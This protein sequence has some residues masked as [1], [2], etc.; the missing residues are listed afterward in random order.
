MQTSYSQNT[1]YYCAAVGCF[2]DTKKVGKYGYM[3][4]VTFFAFPTEKKDPKARRTW[5]NLLRR[6][7][8]ND[9]PRNHRLCSRH[10]VD[11]KPTVTHPYPT[12][13]GY[14]NYK[15][16]KDPRQTTSIA[17]RVYPVDSCTQVSETGDGGSQDRHGSFISQTVK[18]DR[19]DGF[20]LPVV[21]EEIIEFSDEVY[22][23][24]TRPSVPD[25]EYSLQKTDKTEYSQQD[26]STQ[27]DISMEDIS[28]L[29]L[30]EK[31]CEDPNT[32]LKESFI[33]KVTETDA[34]VM[35]YT[36]VQTKSMLMGMF[37]NYHE[38]WI[39][40]LQVYTTGVARAVQTSLTTQPIQVTQTT[41]ERR[42]GHPE[43]CPNMKSSS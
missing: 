13:F 16:A 4:D 8:Y 25:H 12:L 22:D 5:L 15:E 28:R 9:P 32:L 42:E 30:L 21:H 17:K 6:E 40:P 39:E 7:N 43:N 19:E 1:R 34:S 33:R 3:N 11:G 29:L 27:T 18:S 23:Y 26:M 2:S 35:Q 31:K 24:S 37:G 41:K 36:G 10:F 20:P 38:F 14:N